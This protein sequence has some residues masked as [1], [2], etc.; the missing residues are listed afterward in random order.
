MMAMMMIL[1]VTTFDIHDRMNGQRL[2]EDTEDFAEYIQVV[3]LLE[4][5]DYSGGLNTE[6]E[7]L[8]VFE[9]VF[10][11]ELRKLHAN[12]GVVVMLGKP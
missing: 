2:N 9:L 8:V 12:L 4:F 10:V 7:P 6:V 3:V 5:A 11:V 1:M